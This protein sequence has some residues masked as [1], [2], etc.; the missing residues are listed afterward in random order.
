MIQWLL[1]IW[2]AIRQRETDQTEYVMCLVG[3]IVTSRT[4]GEEKVIKHGTN[5]FSPGAKVYCYPAQWGD[6]YERVKVIGT[7]RKSKKK[8]VAV[9]ASKYISNWRVKR[10]FHPFVVAV[11]KNDRAWTDSVA[12]DHKLEEMAKWLNER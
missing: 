12:N 6:G 3:N 1:K 7:H 8:I 2:N 11:M 4:V 10:V 5:Q 9:V